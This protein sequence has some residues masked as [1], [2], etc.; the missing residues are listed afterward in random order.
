[1]KTAYFDCFSGISGNMVIGAFL[2]AGVPLEKLVQE[3]KKIPMDDEYEFITERVSKLGIGAYHFD[4][5]LP[6]HHNHHS[7]QQH[8]QHGHNHGHHHH[9]NFKDIALLLEQSSLSSSVKDL[10]LHT[11]K[12]LGLAEAKVHQCSLED[13]HFHEVGAVD[14]IIDIVGAAFC[15]D[16]LGIEKVIS[17]PLHVGS[18]MVNCAHGL[19]PIPAP[20]TAELLKGAAF[21][22]S[23]I[24]GE[25][26]TPTGAAIITTLAQEFVPLPPLQMDTVAYGAGTMDLEIPNILRLFIGDLKKN[27]YDTDKST[28]IETNIDD[29]NPEICTH[30][31]EKLFKAGAVDVFFTPIYMKKNR[32]GMLISVISNLP[33]PQPLIDIVLT[34]TSTLGVRTYQAKRYK[35]KKAMETLDT[36]YGPVRIKSGYAGSERKNIAPEFEDCRVIAEKTG[37]PLKNI[38]QEIINIYYEKYLKNKSK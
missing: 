16:Y 24:R 1:M 18:G 20:A 22:S 10:A 30:L 36:I 23:D 14:T 15:L 6:H 19:M 13:V 2:D 5:K 28:V 34:E 31:M 11:F 25:L 29:M 9:R 17:S 35:L 3:L 32:P 38:Y 27:S 37:K 33:D 12:R 7:D 4:V 21:Y 8:H 26:V